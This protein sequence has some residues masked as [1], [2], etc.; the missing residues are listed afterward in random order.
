MKLSIAIACFIGF[1]R[2]LDAV[3]LSTSQPSKTPTATP[4][5][6]PTATPTSVPT[7][8]P[9]FLP[10]KTPTATP[11]TIPTATPTLIP[12]ASPT[13]PTALPTFIPTA[14]PTKVD[15]DPNEGGQNYCCP[16]V[17]DK[18]TV[19]IRPGVTAI[20]DNAFNGCQNLASIIIPESVNSIGYSAFYGCYPLTSTVVIPNNVTTMGTYVFCRSGITS[21]T[22]GSGLTAIPE[23]TFFYSYSLKSIYIPRTIYRINTY[24]FYGCLHLTSII[25]ADNSILSI[26]NEG[27]F[28]GCGI[29]NITLPSNVYSIGLQ[30]FA[31]CS[32]LTSITLSNSVA[33]SSSLQGY[34]QVFDEGPLARVTFARC[35]Y[36]ADYTLVTYTS[37]GSV[38]PACIAP[39]ASPTYSPT[40]VDCDPNEGGQNYCCPGAGDKTTVIIR[41]GVTSI[42]AYALTSCGTLTSITL[43]SSLTSLGYRAFYLSSAL[44]TIIMS[45][46]L[47]GSVSGNSSFLGTPLVIFDHNNT[48]TGP[49]FATCPFLSRTTSVTFASV[50]STI[51]PACPVSAFPTATPTS[52][53]TDTPTSIPTLVP[54]AAPSST[55]TLV[56][57]AEPSFTPTSVPTSAPTENPT[58][59]PTATPTKPT[60]SPTY[61]PTRVDCDPNEGGQNYCCP[62]DGDKTTVI[63]R[64]GVTA[65]PSIAFAKCGTVT[66]IT[67][68]S[69]VTSLGDYLFYQC[70]VLTSITLP[71]NV[72][73]SISLNGNFDGTPLSAVAFATCAYFVNDTPITYTADGAT[74]TCYTS[75]PTA[76]PT[77]PTARPTASPTNPTAAPTGTPTPIPTTSPTNPTATPTAIPTAA[78]TKVDCD[79]NEGGQNYC[80]P[81]VN[82]KTTVIIRP[83][84][85]AIPELAF[86]GCDTM[87][88]IIIPSSVTTVGGKAF[89][90][91]ALTSMT[92]SYSL[93]S[94]I[95]VDVFSYLY[96]S[97]LASAVFTSCIYFADDRLVTYS[98]DG[99][100][101]PA[102]NNLTDTP[103]AAPTDAPT[104][105]PTAAPTATPSVTLTSAPTILTG[106]PTAMPNAASVTYFQATLTISSLTAAAARWSS[107]STTTIT[108]Y[109]VAQSGIVTGVYDSLSD[110]NALTNNVVIAIAPGYNGNDN[111]FTGG[112]TSPYGITANGVGFTNSGTSCGLSYSSTAFTLTC[113]SGASLTT[114]PVTS[115]SIVSAATPASLGGSTNDNG[116][117]SSNNTSR[118]LAAL[119]VLVVIPI[120]LCVGLYW[121]YTYRKAGGGSGGDVDSST[122]GPWTPGHNSDLNNNNEKF[123]EVY[124]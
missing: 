16:G 42:P 8:S 97:P 1:M 84:V 124:A 36:F 46:S 7:S 75:T 30:V 40:R 89:S 68:P 20:P 14:N 93:A 91:S 104:S 63:I 71:N 107:Q 56:P 51:S 19:I 29:T 73:D 38:T 24:A 15:C 79:P 61:S 10:T 92:L 18:T 106:S 55:P 76:S 108:T 74:P 81:G 23:G 22:I 26:L 112:S 94:S 80:C 57:T 59:E 66:S 119:A 60:A 53:P 86:Y 101:S 72:A 85:T 45:N 25:I 48:Y 78:P 39:T 52:L 120:A 115:V 116:S 49:R 88:S 13:N 12:T 98:S 109:Y 64:P 114:T 9:T 3:V 58:F 95:L 44:N 87:I 110:Y 37:T 31:S 43:P 83:G 41:P 34:G 47:A 2:R 99:L 90:F 67:I 70:P 65:I 33:G 96:G 35:T 100:F 5:F 17:N 117:T 32:D 6:I 4:T 121:Y 21:I 102:C 113:G 27:A 118:Y 105:A 69:S 103:T 54:T 28:A 50:G 77:N 11:T 123:S 111:V 82:D 122:R 62:G